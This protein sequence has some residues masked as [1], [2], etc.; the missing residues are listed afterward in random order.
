MSRFDKIS[1]CFK[2]CVNSFEEKAVSPYERECFYPC[3]ENQ[4]ILS[5]ELH[6]NQILFNQKKKILQEDFTSN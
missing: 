5:V 4:V 2:K 3:I 1:F 6:N